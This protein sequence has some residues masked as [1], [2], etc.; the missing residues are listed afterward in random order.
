MIKQELI[1]KLEQLMQEKDHV[2]IAIDGPNHALGARIAEQLQQ[3]YKCNIFRTSNYN[4]LPDDLTSGSAAQP[5][6][7]LDCARL[8]TEVIEPL[9]AGA[10]V[11]FRV[12]SV[13]AMSYMPAMPVSARKLN[14]IEGVYSM[15]P[16]LAPLYDLTVFAPANSVSYASEAE[17][18]YYN[19]V[20]P[21]ADIIL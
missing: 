20:C 18:L 7:R 1:E 15:H 8:R 12:Y 21:A 16:E 5:G 13:I 11:S 14:I 4:R 17:A 10:D 3:K 2:V 6:G 9:R 19:T